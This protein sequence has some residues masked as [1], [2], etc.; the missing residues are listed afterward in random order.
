MR[1]PVSKCPPIAILNQLHDDL[2][3]FHFSSSL[4]IISIS[5]PSWATVG[6]KEPEAKVVENWASESSYNL[7]KIKEKWFVGSWDVLRKVYLLYDFS[8]RYTLENWRQ[9]TQ[10]T[11][12]LWPSS[13]YVWDVERASFSTWLSFSMSDSLQRYSVRNC[14]CGIEIET[15]EKSQN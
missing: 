1:S 8:T 4:N 3:L 5:Q 6:D 9:K 10:R 7:D 2:H 15:D 11:F 14:I 12:W 13:F